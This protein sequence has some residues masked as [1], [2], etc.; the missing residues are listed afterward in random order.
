MAQAFEPRPSLGGRSTVS[1]RR[2]EH[3]CF[4]ILKNSEIVQCL[5]ELGLDVTEDTLARCRADSLHGV[6]EHLLIDCLDVS[7]EDLHQPKFYG[8]DALKHAELHEDSVPAMHFVRAM[9]KLLVAAGVSAGF[10]VR[11]LVKPDARRTRR[12]LS[13]IINFHKFRDERLAV[14]EK[15]TV[16]TERLMAARDEAAAE[17]DALA[18]ELAAERERRAAEQPELEALRSECLELGTEIASLNQ[19]QARMRQAAA[20]TK[21][22]IAAAKARSVAAVASRKEAAADTAAVRARVVGDPDSVK[23]RLAEAAAALEDEKTRLSD[24]DRRRRETAVKTD[25]VTAATRDVEKAAT[26]PGRPSDVWGGA[27]AGALTPARLMAG[28]L[29]PGSAAAAGVP[30]AHMDS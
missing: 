6:Y 30:F 17:R 15:M 10:C 23:A 8:L 12:N 9:D 2:K 28:A 3:F 4:P 5:N 26:T 21:E 20:E 7:K 29:T 18:A 16:E 11:D 19:Q 14:F 1:H 24:T 27:D 22:A 13:A 25:V